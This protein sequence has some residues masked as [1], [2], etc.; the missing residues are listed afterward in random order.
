MWVFWGVPLVG[1]GRGRQGTLC[2][3]NNSLLSVSVNKHVSVDFSFSC[4]LRYKN[5]IWYVIPSIVV[6]CSLV[7][8]MH[9]ACTQPVSMQTKL[10]AWC[11]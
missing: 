5:Y 2:P 3:K 1:E 9:P 10:V 8:T 4:Y 7:I 6:N 11:T